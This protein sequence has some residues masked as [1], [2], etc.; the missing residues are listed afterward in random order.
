MVGEEWDDPIHTEGFVSGRGGRVER[1]RLDSIAAYES[2]MIGS[3]SANIAIIPMCC[4]YHC[5]Y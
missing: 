3:S 5:T 4:K 1:Q 2:H